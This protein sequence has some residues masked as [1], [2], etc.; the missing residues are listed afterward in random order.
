MQGVTGI[1]MVPQCK[2]LLVKQWH[3]NARCYWYNN[4]STMQGVTGKTMARQ[5]KV[6][7]VTMVPQCKVLLV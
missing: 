6:L 5:C 1:T 4:G 7:L 2:V 3:D